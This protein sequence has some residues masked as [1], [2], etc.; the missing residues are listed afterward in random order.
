MTGR[1]NNTRPETDKTLADLGRGK[2]ER[3]VL[4]SN[5][6]GTMAGIVLAIVVFVVLFGTVFY[7]A[8]G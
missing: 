2:A 3:V 5:P 1:T 7:F 6:W 8:R 4:G